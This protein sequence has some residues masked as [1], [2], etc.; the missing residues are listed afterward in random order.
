[1]Q[2]APIKRIA[3][4][5]S[6]TAETT[7]T[8]IIPLKPAHNQKRYYHHGDTNANVRNPYNFVHIFIKTIIKYTR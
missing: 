8:D 5:R 3:F 2:H 1:M 4:K 7:E 6:E